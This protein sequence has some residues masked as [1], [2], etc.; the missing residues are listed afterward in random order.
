[1]RLRAEQPLPLGPLTLCLR[2]RAGSLWGD[3]PPYEAFPLG[4]ANSVRGYAEGGVGSARAFLE[5]SAEI[6]CGSEW[7]GIEGG[8][9]IQCRCCC[10]TQVILLQRVNWEHDC[11]HPES[12]KPMPLR[13]A[14]TTP[15]RWT[16]HKPVQ[17][18][19]FTDYATDLDSGES[20]IGDPAGARGKLGRCA[21][22][23]GWGC[24]TL[25]FTALQLA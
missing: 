21:G 7:G 13:C 11:A 9:S 12:K 16:I 24:T 5:G 1:M 4:G 3:L 25:G 2:G 17:G 19:L 22:R 14:A 6:R 18:V 8:Y 10:S 23:W 20:V 15:A